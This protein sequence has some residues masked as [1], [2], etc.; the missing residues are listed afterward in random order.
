MKGKCEYKKYDYSKIVAKKS[1]TVW[2][3]STI[4]N[5]TEDEL[6]N[7]YAEQIRRE[8][9]RHI[10]SYLTVNGMQSGPTPPVYINNKEEFVKVYGIQK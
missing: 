10:L 9:D 6:T 3:T 1:N 8:I 2:Y 7:A 4:F 5:S